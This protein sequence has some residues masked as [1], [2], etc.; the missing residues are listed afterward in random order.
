MNNNIV[1]FPQ[2]RFER[3]RHNIIQY[4]TD[5]SP[6]DIVSVRR[7]FEYSKTK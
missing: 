2:Y 3:Y 5:I 7:I 1:L 4:V 6:P